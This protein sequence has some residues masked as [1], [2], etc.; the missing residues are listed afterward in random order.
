MR[1][2][3]LIALALSAVACATIT[4][5]TTQV[6]AIDTPGAPGAACIVSTPAGP[7]ELM[8]PGTIT[9]AKSS[10]S[11][12]VRCTKACHQ[13][14][15][16]VLASGVEV[17]SAGNLIVGGVVGI[18]IDAASGAMHKYPDQISVMMIP[19]PGCGGGSR[20]GRAKPGDVSANDT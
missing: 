19:I 11:L 12:P 20:R 14:G 8:T 17:M 16:G 9:L 7:Q 10:N 3:V 4:K 5:G 1:L 2:V 6:V 18:G 13:E 15:V